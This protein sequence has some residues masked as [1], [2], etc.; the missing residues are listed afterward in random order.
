MS[1][2][3]RRR[4]RRQGPAPPSA[5]ENF[6]LIEAP[7]LILK[8]DDQGETRERNLAVAAKLTH[9]LSGILHV[10]GAGHNVRRDQKARTLAALLPFLEKCTQ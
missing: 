5:A 8:A 7:T 1:L 2:L 9:P 10:E 4:G 3:G 6:E